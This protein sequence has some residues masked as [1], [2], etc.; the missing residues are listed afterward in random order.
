MQIGLTESLDEQDILCP[1]GTGS[2]CLFAIVGNETE[3]SCAKRMGSETAGT[4]IRNWLMEVYST[5]FIAILSCE[6]FI[7]PLRDLD[8]LI[9]D[10]NVSPTLNK[11]LIN[12]HFA[13]M[14]K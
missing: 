5:D 4:K 7:H 1:P 13:T 10:F 9:S 8:R 6:R 12:K 14:K 11:D 2:R 3:S